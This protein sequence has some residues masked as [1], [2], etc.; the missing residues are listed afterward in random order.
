MSEMN[1][2]RE[3]ESQIKEQQELSEGKYSANK[4]KMLHLCGVY[5]FFCGV[6]NDEGGEVTLDFK[7][8]NLHAVV[9][10]KV[11]CVDL[12]REGM[13]QFLDILQYVDKLDIK[14]T[15]D[16]LLIDAKVNDVWEAV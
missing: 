16:Y 9:H 10:A 12:R 15:P 1:F 4:Q 7:P 11:E 2:D 3:L 5:S 8:E 13:R 6:A 14:A